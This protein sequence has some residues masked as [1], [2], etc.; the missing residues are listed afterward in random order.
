[1]LA[2]AQRETEFSYD[3]SPRSSP[4]FANVAIQLAMV[5]HEQG[6]TDDGISIL[7]QLTETQPQNDVL[8]SAQGYLLQKLGRY[9]EARDVLLQGL[10]VA[11]GTATEIHYN[12]GLIYIELGEFDEATKHA[13]IA[14]D[15]GF[16]LQGLRAKLKRGGHPL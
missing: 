13:K 3:T 10:S 8:Y 4:Q 11:N 9:T 2:E 12:L 1:M 14:Y 5:L 16:P 7:Q 6:S 15:N